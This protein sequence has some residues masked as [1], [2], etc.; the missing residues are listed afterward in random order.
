HFVVGKLPDFS[1]LSENP[2]AD[3][4]AEN[5]V[6]PVPEQVA[7][8]LD[9]P[10]WRATYDRHRRRILDALALGHRTKDVAQS[11]A[12][13]QGR[14]SQLRSEYRRDWRRLTGDSSLTD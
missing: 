10:A 12:M 6:S 7:F 2:L 4:L 11:F 1:T 9:F 5:T 14:V 3:A 13:S 8:R